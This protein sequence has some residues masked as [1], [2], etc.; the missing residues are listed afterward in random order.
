VFSVA[1]LMAA[2]GGWGSGGCSPD[3]GLPSMPFAPPV[4]IPA[5][6]VVR[7]PPIENGV[8][9]GKLLRVE[10]EH[11]DGQRWWYTFAAPPDVT[12]NLDTANSNAAISLAGG[13]LPKDGKC[14]NKNCKCSPP[15]SCSDCKCDDQP[16]VGQKPN[17]GINE[18]EMAKRAGRNRYSTNNGVEISKTETNRLFRGDSELPDDS[19]YDMLAVIGTQEQC[20]KIKKDV[21]SDPAFAPLRDKLLVQCYRPE[22]E[23]VKRKGFEPGN[24]SIYLQ[25]STG[26]TKWREVEYRGPKILAGEIDKR[27]PDYDPNKDPG[28]HN[29]PPLIPS[30]PNIDLQALSRHPL[31]LIVA[32]FAALMFLNRKPV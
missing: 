22:D 32:A 23:M 13:N 2:L 26:K 27:R 20:D 3:G 18:K 8:A 12:L 6:P 21:D 25:S 5:P 9:T 16:M 24:P 1:L 14:T 17:F 7:Q 28:P 19:A 30:M 15:C 11:A 10:I 29:P 31:V 4:F